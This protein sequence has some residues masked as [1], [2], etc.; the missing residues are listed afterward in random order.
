M[1]GFEPR[2]SGLGS[3]RSTNW[4]TTTAQI[5][6]AYQ[7]DQKTKP[8]LSKAKVCWNNALCGQSYKQFTLVIYN[9]TVVIWDIF[10]SGTTLES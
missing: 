3:D 4:A 5:K 2:T 8:N 9:S 7:Q 6:K 1:T 10:K